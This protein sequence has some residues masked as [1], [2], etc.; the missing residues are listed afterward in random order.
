MHYINA[1]TACISIHFLYAGLALNRISFCIKRDELVS[2]AANKLGDK[3]K[4]DET[5]LGTLPPHLWPLKL[6]DF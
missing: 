5:K 6:L 4:G 1:I 3:V 2:I